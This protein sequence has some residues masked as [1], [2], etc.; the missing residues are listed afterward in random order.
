MCAEHSL[1]PSS[2]SVRENVCPRKANCWQW[3]VI[4]AVEVTVQRPKAR[5]VRQ[6]PKIIDLHDA[7]VNAEQCALAQI[8][9]H[10]VDMDGCEAESIR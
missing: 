8:P 4:S 5:Q 6:A 1:A 9:Q 2:S 7:G 10:P 3:E